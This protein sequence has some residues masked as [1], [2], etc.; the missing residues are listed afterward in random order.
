MGTI[1]FKEFYLRMASTEEERKALDE[2]IETL[3]K[4]KFKQQMLPAW[5]PVPSFASTMVT[6][7]IFGIVFLAIGI[8]LYV[9]SDKIQEVELKYAPEVDGCNSWT[10]P[11]T[12]NPNPDNSCLMPIEI[13]E[14]MEGNIFVY[15]QL[16]NFYQNHRRYV[17]SRDYKQLMGYTGGDVP[18]NTILPTDTAE[19]AATKNTNAIDAIS[20]N[21]EPITTN[22]NLANMDILEYYWVENTQ[23]NRDAGLD[24]PEY[25]QD[26]TVEARADCLKLVETQVA[27]PCGLIAKSMF[28]DTYTL[29]RDSDM[30]E[31]IAIDDTGIA[32]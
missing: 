27:M 5:R 14:P 16:T 18:E 11:T 25:C 23:E 15:Y 21:C 28:T 9:M 17:K 4:S 2:K 12:E 22:A 13:T 3:K 32:W 20:T 6:F 30:T 7:A 1:K 19:E 26:M 10:I 24:I 8:M 29:Y 31:E